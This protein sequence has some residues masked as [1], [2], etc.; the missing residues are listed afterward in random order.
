M[1]T[2]LPDYSTADIYHLA[3]SALHFG[4]YVG[5]AVTVGLATA[6]ITFA[7]YQWRMVRQVATLA[8]GREI[9]DEEA[10]AQVP[11]SESDFSGLGDKAARK[12]R[13]DANR[14]SGDAIK[15]KG[16][17]Y[18]DE[19]EYFRELNRQAA[20]FY[21]RSVR[22]KSLAEIE[23]EF[24]GRYGPAPEHTSPEDKRSSVRVWLEDNE[25]VQGMKKRY[26]D[27]HISAAS[28]AADDD[29]EFADAR[30]AEAKAVAD[31]NRRFARTAKA[32]RDG[33]WDPYDEGYRD[34]PMRNYE[35]RK[36]RR[37]TDYDEFAHQRRTQEENYE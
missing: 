28:D 10:A 26:Q 30:R 29:D 3:L 19:T 5:F 13:L 25:F 31:Q 9:R 23:S 14:K 2:P 21:R 18:V 7:F 24:D 4:P 15:R 1:S 34:K 37:R 6:G 27:F 33:R 20:D 22:E 16:K 12:R 17:W 8:N 32:H 36:S 35:G 11:N